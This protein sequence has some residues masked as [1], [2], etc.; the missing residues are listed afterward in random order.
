MAKRE[1]VTIS[2]AAD[3]LAELDEIAIARD[4]NRSAL[5][6]EALAVWEERR[7]KRELADGYKAMAAEDRKTAEANLRSGVEILERGT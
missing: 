2:I 3:R 1:K 6:E 5:I 7:L 4:T